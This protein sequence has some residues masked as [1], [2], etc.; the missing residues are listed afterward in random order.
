AL[1][2]P[3]KTFVGAVVVFLGSLAVVPLLGTAFIPEMKE[4]SVVPGINRVPNI[5]L[6]ESIRMEQKAMAL[7]MTVPGV[8]S[9]VS[10]VGRGES[11]ADP[12]GQ[13]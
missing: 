2:S 12:Q 6:E 7:V 5:S 8:K 1:E 4:G 9:A 10:S 13:N 11:P 3:K